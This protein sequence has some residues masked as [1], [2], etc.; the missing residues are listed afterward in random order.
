[1][2]RRAHGMPDRPIDLSD[3]ALGMTDPLAERR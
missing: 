1:M 2:L 3:F